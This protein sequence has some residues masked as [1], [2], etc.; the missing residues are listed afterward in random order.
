[1]VDNEETKV[2]RKSKIQKYSTGNDRTQSEREG[3]KEGGGGE[4]QNNGE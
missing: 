2:G 4:V 3:R 1:M